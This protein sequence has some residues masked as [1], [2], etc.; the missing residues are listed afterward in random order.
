M[1]EQII[2]QINSCLS[3]WFDAGVAEHASIKKKL[4]YQANTSYVKR[5]FLG[6]VLRDFVWMTLISNTALVQGVYVT[7]YE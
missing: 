2:G 6:V 5:E 1:W 7:L 3:I 4:L